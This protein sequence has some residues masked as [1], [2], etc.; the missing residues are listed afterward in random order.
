MPCHFIVSGEHTTE[1][2]DH[3]W[4]DTYYEHRIT[5][6][7]CIQYH[8]ITIQSQLKTGSVQAVYFK[9]GCE[10]KKKI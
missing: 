6:S 10:K 3:H 2:W 7:L 5:Q 8:L 1:A 4:D 9:L